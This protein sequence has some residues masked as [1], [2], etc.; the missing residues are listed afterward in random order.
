MLE[1]IEKEIEVPCGQETAFDVFIKEMGSW[2]PLER[3]SVSAMLGGPSKALKVETR[4]G[5]TITEVAHDGSEHLWGTITRYD[6]HDHLALDFHIPHPEHSPEDRT[7]DFT[8]VELR[9]MP[10]ESGRTRVTLTQSNWEA[11][12]D[13]AEM[14]RGGYGTGWNMIFE[15]RYREACASTPSD[16]FGA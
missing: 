9:F 1:P 4:E 5:G 10:L 13:M 12:G 14:V 8:R 15:E 7:G 3:F 11:L 16:A 6:P 2:W